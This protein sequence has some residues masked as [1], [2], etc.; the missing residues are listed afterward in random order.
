[1]IAAIYAL[2]LARIVFELRV[3]TAATWM[4]CLLYMSR[5]VKWSGATID[6]PELQVMLGGDSFLPAVPLVAW[7]ERQ[8]DGCGRRS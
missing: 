8:W 3:A 2:R 1:M 5:Y 7:L 6:G 4:L